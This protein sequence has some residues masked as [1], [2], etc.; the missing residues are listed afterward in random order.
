MCRGLCLGLGFLLSRFCGSFI[1][2]LL[3]CLFSIGIVGWCRHRILRYRTHWQAVFLGY[4]S[5]RLNPVCN[6]VIFLFYCCFRGLVWGILLVH[7]KDFYH[8]SLSIRYGGYMFKI[9]CLIRLRKLVLIWRYRRR[10]FVYA[11]FCFCC[12]S[13]RLIFG[14]GRCIH[15]VEVSLISPLPF[16]N[17]FTSIFCYIQKISTNPQQLFF[18]Q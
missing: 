2:C 11:Q 12:L 18:N 14:W 8:G 1:G 7:C 16:L 9:I 6:H 3:F 13:L 4:V 17:I 5:K 10:K 15:L